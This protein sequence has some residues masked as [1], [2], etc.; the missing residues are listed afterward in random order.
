MNAIR[1]TIRVV[2]IVAVILCFLFT[3]RNVIR[4][5]KTSAIVVCPD[6]KEKPAVSVLV[7]W[8]VSVLVGRGRWIISFRIFII[9]AVM[10]I[11]E[12][13]KIAFVFCFLR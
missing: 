4:P 8:C 11:V 5:K 7:Y 6:G 2:V 12:A 13:K 1:A 10:I 9:V 3:N